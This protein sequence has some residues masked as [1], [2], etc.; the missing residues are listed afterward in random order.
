MPFLL[1]R[2]ASG[3]SINLNQLKEISM[4]KTTP[5]AALRAAWLEAPSGT[6]MPFEALDLV[7]LYDTLST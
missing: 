5:A 1:G 2:A 3:H 7:N 6:G 4:T